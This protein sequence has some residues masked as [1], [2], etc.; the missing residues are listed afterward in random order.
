MPDLKQF[1]DDIDLMIGKLEQAKKEEKDRKKLLGIEAV[2]KTLR[3]KR[4]ATVKKIKKA[5]G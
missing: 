3:R 2:L 5:R 1:L 4:R